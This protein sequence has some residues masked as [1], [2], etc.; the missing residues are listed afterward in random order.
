ML[1]GCYVNLDFYYAESKIEKHRKNK[2]IKGVNNL[3][4]STCS[5]VFLV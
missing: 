1:S 4:I 2:E 3:R 5:L